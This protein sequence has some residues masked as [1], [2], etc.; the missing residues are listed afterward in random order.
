MKIIK[1]S[2]KPLEQ[3]EIIQWLQEARKHCYIQSSHFAVAAVIEIKQGENYL[4]LIGVNVEHPEYNRLGMHAE[5]NAITLLQ[6]LSEKKSLFSKIWV[7]GAPEGINFG[8]TH[9]LA[10]NPVTPCGQC[11]QI[12]ASFSENNTQVFSVT[13][14]GNVKDIGKLTDLL[15]QGFSERDLPSP[16]HEETHPEGEKT[17]PKVSTLFEKSKINVLDL[18]I[19]DKQLT[20]KREIFQ[21]LK[22]L[23][24][25]IIDPQFITSPI[26]K[27]MLTLENNVCVPGVLVEDIAFLTTDAVFT[28]LAAAITRFGSHDLKVK[29]IHLYSQNEKVE[30]SNLLKSSEIRALAP[31]SASSTPVYC[32][33]DHGLQLQSTLTECHKAIEVPFKDEPVAQ[34]EFQ[35]EF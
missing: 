3:D 34:A 32:Y 6:T 18:F 33:N 4:Y 27:V 23:T 11:R 2:K 7:M 15:P 29:E 30:N 9:P 13:V 5:Q 26:T 12:T 22:K 35:M 24:P 8:S 17:S 21:Y 1:Q 31:F 25:H 14:N 20:D 19:L 10:D 16:A 28:A